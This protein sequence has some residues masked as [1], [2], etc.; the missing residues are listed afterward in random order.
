MRPRLDFK[1]HELSDLRSAGALR[2]RFDMNK[3][4]L[5]ALSG[6]DEPEAAV[7]VPGLDASVEAHGYVG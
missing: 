6:L 4:L 5:A 2:E 3:D 7:I 1:R